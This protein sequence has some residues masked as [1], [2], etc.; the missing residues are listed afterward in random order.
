MTLSG[1]AMTDASLPISPTPA[2]PAPT[3]PAPDYP[4]GADMMV[5]VRAHDEQF[6]D[7][8]PAVARYRVVMT[9]ARVD[10]PE[11]QVLLWLNADVEPAQPAPSDP[12]SPPDRPADLDLVFDTAHDA[13]LLAGHPDVIAS[14]ADLQVNAHADGAERRLRLWLRDS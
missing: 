13:G 6:W 7:R 1:A 3:K 9:P 2:D 11:W 5:R 4:E 14:Q 12:T 10:D 8:H